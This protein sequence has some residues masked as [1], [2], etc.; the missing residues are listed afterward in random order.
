APR[1]TALAVPADPAA[2]SRCAPGGDVFEAFFRLTADGARPTTVLDTRA[3]DH[4]HLTARGITEVVTSD[5]VLHH[6]RGGTRS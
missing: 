1:T 4:A 6:P 5:Q 3:A 2:R